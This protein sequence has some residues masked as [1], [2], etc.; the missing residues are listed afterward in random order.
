M[1]KS[2]SKLTLLSLLIFSVCFIG[3]GEEDGGEGVIRG[4]TDPAADNFNASATEDDGSCVIVGC[5]DPQAVNFN[6]DATEDD[7]ECIYERDVFIASY[8][9]QFTCQNPIISFINSDSLLFEIK[10][11]VDE[12]DKMTAVLSLNI[13][14]LPVDFNGS[15]DGDVFTVSDTLMNVPIPAL[16]ITADRVSGNGSAMIL[17]DGMLEGS[18]TLELEAGIINLEDDCTITGSKI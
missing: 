4:C 10:E 3:C 17:D 7:G 8:L 18:I 2:L 13:S 6:A 9:G 15:V 16:N 11:P 14:G 5:T 12:S 1:M